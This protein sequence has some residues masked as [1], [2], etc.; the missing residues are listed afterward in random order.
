MKVLQS[1]RAAS[2]DHGRGCIATAEVS[3]ASSSWVGEIEDPRAASLACVSRSA[4]AHSM[5]FCPFVRP[6]RVALDRHAREDTE[7]ASTEKSRDL[8]R[9]ESRASARLPARPA[10]PIQSRL[11]FDPFLPSSPSLPRFIK[12]PPSRK[13]TL[14]TSRNHRARSCSEPSRPR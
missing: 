13:C 4:F 7:A 14:A 8:D 12:P 6:P 3:P 9:P 11:A 10:N 1:T 2:S 5:L